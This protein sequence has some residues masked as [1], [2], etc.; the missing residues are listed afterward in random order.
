MAACGGDGSCIDEPAQKR[1]EN[2]GMSMFP[3]IQ[4]QESIL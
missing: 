1:A 2:E 3:Q 4:K